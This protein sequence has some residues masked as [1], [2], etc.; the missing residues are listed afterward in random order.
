VYRL[1]PILSLVS[2]HFGLRGPHEQ[3]FG[4]RDQAAVLSRARLLAALRLQEL[5]HSWT[6]QLVSGQQLVRGEDEQLRRCGQQSSI[7]S[8]FRAAE[9][10]AAGIRQHPDSSS[11]LELF[12][13]CYFNVT[14]FDSAGLPVCN[15]NVTF[16]SFSF[17][18][19]EWKG[20]VA[21][22]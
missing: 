21:F 3:L 19:A 22:V 1:W 10:N 2:G 18:Q 9:L 16:N 17:T 14:T 15:R 6:V 13:F 12:T 11:V 7:L 4:L 5:H 8:C 20:V